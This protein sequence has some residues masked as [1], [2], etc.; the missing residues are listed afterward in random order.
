MLYSEYSNY[1]LLKEK[2]RFLWGAGYFSNFQIL[3]V[4]IKIR[5][6]LLLSFPKDTLQYHSIDFH[7]V[8]QSFET[9]MLCQHRFLVAFIS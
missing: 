6:L 3:K 7:I 1:R 4:L 5:Q 2:A 8:K 9:N